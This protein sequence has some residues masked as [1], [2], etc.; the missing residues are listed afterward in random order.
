MQKD[1]RR[2]SKNIGIKIGDEYISTLFFANDQVIV[3]GC[4]ERADYMF[5]KLEKKTHK[6]NFTTLTL[7][8]QSN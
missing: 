8:K 7:Q 6:N 4:T 1:W 2:R 3:A 5:K